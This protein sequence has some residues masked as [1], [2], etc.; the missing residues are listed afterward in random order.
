MSPAFTF[1]HPSL[2]L[3][4]PRQEIIILSFLSLLKNAARTNPMA[5]RLYRK[6]RV[7]QQQ[8]NHG[9]ATFDLDVYTS[10]C[11]S[12]TVK[13]VVDKRKPYLE[14]IVP[15][16]RKISSPSPPPSSPPPS[17]SS[18]LYHSLYQRVS[19]APVLV[20]GRSGQAHHLSIVLGG[21]GSGGCRTLTPINSPYTARLLKPYIF[22]STEL[23]SLHTRLMAEIVSCY[24]KSHHDT[25]PYCPPSIDLCYLQR[26]HVRPVNA[27]LSHFFWPVDVTECLQYPDSTVV[28]LCGQLVVGCGFMTPDVNVGEAYISFLLVH[29][30]FAG[31]GLGKMMLYHLVQSCRGKDVALHVSVDNPAML[32]YQSFGFKAERFCLDFYL[33]YHPPSHP[34]SNHAYFMRLW[35]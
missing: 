12:S 11:L 15:V 21:R 13:Y 1:S 25:P 5:S 28:A 30:H 24:R 14:Q 9:Y 10:R 22:R 23:S 7:R 35:R 2:S 26:E 17:S 16:T 20:Q 32:L 4:S 8:R 29:P 33:R 3:L 34:H 18:L 27:L 6:L 31:V 19:L